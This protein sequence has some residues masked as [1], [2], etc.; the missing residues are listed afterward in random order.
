MNLTSEQIVELSGFLN[1]RA[2]LPVA[3]QEI[4]ASLKESLAPAPEQV[5]A[6][7]VV[8]EAPVVSEEANG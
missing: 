5:E 2:D 4:A 3:I 7:P 8:E 6:A 1:G